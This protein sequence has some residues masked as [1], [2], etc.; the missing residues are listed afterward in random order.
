M[1]L[2]ITGSL[3]TMNEII[4]AAKSHPIAYRNMKKQYT[5]LVAWEAKAQKIQPFTFAD[6][7]FTWLCRS[8]MTD[9][10]NIIAGQKFVFDGIKEAGCMPND[11]WKQVGEIT[12]KF[13]VDQKRPRVEIEILELD[14]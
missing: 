14:S 1:K 8:K 3:P 5:N 6:F 13:G 10:D 7:T 12:H 9:K 2:I 11:G 4:A